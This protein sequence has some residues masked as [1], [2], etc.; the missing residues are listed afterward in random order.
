[1]C[2]ACN[3]ARWK[4]NNPDYY[5]KRKEYFRE[6]R[7]VTAE[8]TAAKRRKDRFAKKILILETIGKTSCADC[9]NSNPKVL[10]FH[11]LM[12][13]EKSFNVGNAIAHRWHIDKIL[14]ETEKCE[15]LCLNCH[16]LRHHAD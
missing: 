8:K 4:K 1:M 12:P 14:A 13:A 9:G 15:V 5:Q 10:S 2:N 7:K 3:T 11:H 6:Y 16:A